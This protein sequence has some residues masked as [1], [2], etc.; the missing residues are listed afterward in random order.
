MDLEISKKEL[1]RRRER[2][3]EDLAR[4]GIEA[5]CLFIPAQI[6]YVTGFVF[7]PAERPIGLIL[8]KDGETCLF[9]PRV[10]K[11]HALMYA[12][13]DHV[14]SYPEYPGRNHP[15]QYLREIIEGLKL[16]D[17]KIGVDSDGY[18]GR[19]GYVGP[20]L[21]ELLP[22]AEI[23]LAKDVIEEM[24]RIKSDEE[25]ALI[26]ESAKWGHLAHTLLQKYT[27]PGVT[28]TEISFKASFESAITMMHTLGERYRPLSGVFMTAHAG[29]R[30]QVGKYSA[31]PHTMA[32][33]ATIREGDVTITF[34]VPSINGYS[35]EL[36]R[37]MII[38]CPT[39]DQKKYFNLMKN[40]Q[41]VGLESIRPGIRC[42]DVDK[43]VGDFFEKEGLMDYWRH[44]T[45]HAIGLRM[46]EPPFLDIGDDTVIKPGMVFSVEPGIYIP[47]FAGF[48]HSDTVLVTEN[49]IETL[50]YYPR[51]IEDLTIC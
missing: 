24:M 4:R 33:N 1:N 29:F 6:F 17:K 10:E 8:G 15:M 23:K 35:S 30:G 25:I 46:K 51:E 36:E 18:I 22:E 14:E 48:R 34:A 13:V 12:Y 47:D 38:G 39:K 9:V 21:S 20:K 43:A 3:T 19:Y 45:G 31:L 7:I 41:N 26:K 37:T 28:E 42:S 16:T 32:M 2:V 27:E 5:L 44:H 11:E 40:A 50:T 49:G